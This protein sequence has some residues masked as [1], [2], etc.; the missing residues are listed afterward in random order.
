MKRSI[1]GHA[2]CNSDHGIAQT[3]QW[4]RPGVLWIADRNDH[5]DRSGYGSQAD[6]VGPVATRP[7]SSLYQRAVR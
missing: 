4:L 1:S 7:A 3:Q 6:F 5:D 2:D